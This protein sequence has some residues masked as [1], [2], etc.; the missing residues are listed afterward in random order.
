MDDS[1][2][3]FW[4][5]D[6]RPKSEEEQM[7]TRE[8]RNHFI[9]IR[10]KNNNNFA[11]CGPTG[12][13]KSL[14]AESLGNFN[15]KIINLSKQE[16]KDLEVILKKNKIIIMKR[17]EEAT[18]NIVNKINDYSKKNSIY[19][20]SRNADLF[21]KP[22]FKNF[23]KISMEE[24]LPKS[25]TSFT[26]LEKYIKYILNIKNIS[27]DPKNKEFQNSCIELFERLWPNMRQIIRQLQLR[28]KTGEWVSIPL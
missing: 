13:G 14:F 20:T 10:K 2:T 22:D 1:K 24:M 7:F 26:V 18:K 17:V 11:V 12:S 19:I 9:T 15:T 5:L 28:S 21:T 16:P 8:M 4:V 3:G 27:F 25:N 6:L 23:T